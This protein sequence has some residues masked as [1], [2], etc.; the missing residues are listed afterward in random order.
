MLN[1][2]DEVD[3]SYIFPSTS[4]GI[5]SVLNNELFFFFFLSERLILGH[6]G[7]LCLSLGFSDL[8]VIAAIT[9]YREKCVVTTCAPDFKS[10]VSSGQVDNSTV[11]STS[12]HIYSDFKLESFT[13]KLGEGRKQFR[14]IH[15]QMG[16]QIFKPTCALILG[17]T[18]SA[19]TLTLCPCCCVCVA[20]CLS[21]SC[22]GCAWLMHMRV[23][24]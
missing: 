10:W 13:Q 16:K 11:I 18:S 15:M 21:L 14:Q 22:L 23:Y 1:L 3:F 4:D 19:A 17:R 8:S 2:I 24:E 20:V 6:V 5:L 7:R 9:G 12:A